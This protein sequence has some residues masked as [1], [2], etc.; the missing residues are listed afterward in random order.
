MTAVHPRHQLVNWRQLKAD[1][2]FNNIQI[3]FHL[4]LYYSTSFSSPNKLAQIVH[5]TLLHAL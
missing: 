4:T 2:F 5:S 3:Y 1:Q